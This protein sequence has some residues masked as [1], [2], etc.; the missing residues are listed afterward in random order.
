MSH[1]SVS[2]RQARASD[3]QRLGP[4]E[5]SAASVFRSAGLDWLADGDTMDPAVL[6]D[7]CRNATLWIAA[8]RTVRKSGSGFPLERCASLRREHRI[9][10]Q[11]WIPLLGPMLQR[12]EPVG[13]LA[14][15]EMDG[16]FYIAEVSVAQSHQRRGLGARLIGAA[17]AHAKRSGF[18]T[19][20]LTTYRDLAWNG[21]FYASL[22]FVE[23]EPGETWPGHA[24]KLRAEAEAGHDPARRCVMALR[25]D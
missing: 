10:S 23:I 16:H 22:G 18:S 15:H 3:L 13:F 19:V 8:E 14:A 1:S 17:V 11:K 12:D 2:I 4:V 24:A 9:Q 20:T 25:L 6:A 7:L 5:R 21:P